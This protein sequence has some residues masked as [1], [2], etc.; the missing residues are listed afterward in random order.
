MACCSARGVVITLCVLQLVSTVERQVFDFLGYMWAP[1]LGNFL[2]IICV[3]IG[4]FGS[5]QYRP[6][7]IAVYAVWNLLWLGWNIFVIC[8][9]LEVGVL[10]RNKDI[11]I[12]NI[13]TGNKSWWL[14]N[15]IGCIV[16]N[17]TAVESP[18]SASRP[19]PAE[20]AV[21]GCILAYYY[22]EVIHAAVQIFLSIIGIIIS[23]LVIYFITEEDDS[24][25]P[26]NDMLE[27]VKMRYKSPAR[28]SFR[29][30]NRVLGYGGYDTSQSGMGD[31]GG[32]GGIDNVQI[33]SVVPGM[34][35]I[36]DTPSSVD[37]H[38]PSYRAS[39][40][41]Y[42]HQ[43]RHSVRS[44]ASNKSRTS[45]KNTDYGHPQELPWVQI[46][47]SEHE[48]ELPYRQIFPV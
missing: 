28:N 45:K 6:R 17:S 41:N 2:H 18:P 36:P 20:G 16:T 11:Y 22:V 5:L 9:Y 44:K 37:E 19:I 27:Y 34:T 21:Q 43:D 31:F 40:G 35:E 3:I 4:L 26:A 48:H 33:H 14:E 8:L 13:V 23:S 32:S 12:L 47:P 30:Q 39:M 38:P 15:G 24:S 25:A 46:T 10:N 29:E 42:Y 7:F 1:I